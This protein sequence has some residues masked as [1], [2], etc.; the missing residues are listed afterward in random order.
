MNEIP[1]G[2]P[3]RFWDAKLMRLARKLRK[4]PGSSMRARELKEK[5]LDNALACQ[6]QC[7]KL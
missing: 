6:I 4:E 3:F 2:K 7:Q 5:G 1:R